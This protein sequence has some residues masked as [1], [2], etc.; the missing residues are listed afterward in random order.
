MK[1]KQNKNKRRNKHG[2]ERRKE[3]YYKK[4]EIKVKGKEVDTIASNR[5]SFLS[6]KILSNNCPTR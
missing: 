5:E 3:K 6:K 1:G 2:E 4:L